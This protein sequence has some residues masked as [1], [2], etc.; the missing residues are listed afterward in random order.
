MFLFYWF[1]VSN[2]SGLDRG[3]NYVG[4]TQQTEPSV[5]PDLD[6]GLVASIALLLLATSIP[7]PILNEQTLCP[8]P[9]HSPQRRPSRITRLL[10]GHWHG[11]TSFL[12]RHQQ[13]QSVLILTIMAVDCSPAGVN[14]RLEFD[15]GA[16]FVK[17]SRKTSNKVNR[18]VTWIQD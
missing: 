16:W 4:L 12:S 7:L 1:L 6:P 17:G 11:M 10:E 3:E 8:G 14:R 15:L 18:P 2:G 13:I 9:N 5:S